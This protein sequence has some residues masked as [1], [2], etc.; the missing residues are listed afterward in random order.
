MAG[1]TNPG[2]QERRSRRRKHG[3]VVRLHSRERD[4]GQRNDISPRRGGRRNRA[5]VADVGVSELKAGLSIIVLL[6]RHAIEPDHAR[7]GVRDR[8]I[9]YA[10]AV[11]AAAQ[12]RSHDVKA[13]KGKPRTVIDAGD[14]RG[15][16]AVEFADEK[17]FRIDGSKAA[18]IGEAG[19]PAFS[20]R[21]VHG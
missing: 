19:I 16:L 10:Q 6:R 13:E 4:I 8:R 15:R 20:R 18:G 1:R 17:A 21:P 12:I 7:A 2:P 5:A 11:A 3:G 14:G 9:P